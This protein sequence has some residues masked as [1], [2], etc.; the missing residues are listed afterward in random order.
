MPDLAGSLGGGGRYDDLV[1]MFLGRDVPACGFSLGLERI[2]V[3]MSERNMFPANLTKPADVLVTLWDESSISYSLKVAD[4]L[5]RQGTRVFV[6][7]QPDKLGK[8]LKYAS[9]LGI[10]LVA[11]MGPDERQHEIIA[12]K[13][14]ESGTQQVVTSDGE[15]TKEVTKAR[16]ERDVFVQFASAAELDLDLEFIENQRFTKPDLSCKIDCQQHYFVIVEIVD[17]DLARNVAISLET[18]KITGGAFSYEEPLKRAFR[19]KASKRYAVDGPLELLAF[20]DKQYPPTFD[21]NLIPKTVGLIAQEMI[22]SGRWYRIWVY[23]RWKKR[24]LWVWQ[25]NQ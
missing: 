22:N 14:L 9:Q 16:L 11:V 8:Q 15:K 20:F 10:P 25:A 7:P 2:L 24:I 21:L 3:V 17:E 1:G 12:L 6:Y 5:R 23:D 4:E 13:D 19:S 18:M